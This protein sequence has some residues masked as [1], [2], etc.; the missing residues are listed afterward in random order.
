MQSL[1]STGYNW[2]IASE[3]TWGYVWLLYTKESHTEL[4][5]GS[6]A[7]EGKSWIKFGMTSP[8]QRWTIV[9]IL[10]KIFTSYIKLR[11]IHQE[12][13]K[14][15]NAHNP[16]CTRLYRLSNMFYFIMKFRIRSDNFSTFFMKNT[17]GFSYKKLNTH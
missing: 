13:D 4:D 7:T 3:E 14:Q 11:L 2:S 8:A 17:P 9:L 16:K 1:L 10:L 15:H 5:S 6:R 12:Y